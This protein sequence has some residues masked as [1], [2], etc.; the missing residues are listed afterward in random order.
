MDTEELA[1]LRAKCPVTAQ[2][3]FRGRIK[4]SHFSI[5]SRATLGHTQPPIQWVAGGGGLSP[6]VKRPGR[7]GDHSPPT[8]AEVKKTWTYILTAPEV[9]ME[10]CLTGYLSSSDTAFHEN[11]MSAVLELMLTDSRTH[12]ATV[13]EGTMQGSDAIQTHQAVFA[14]SV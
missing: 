2:S 6:E 10:Q 12:S 14:C 7:E 3:T 13:F 4:I 5:S 11:M 1:S 8:S 9:F